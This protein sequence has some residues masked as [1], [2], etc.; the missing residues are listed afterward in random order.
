[1]I[2]VIVYEDNERLRHTLQLLM[3]SDSSLLLIGNY[4]DCDN[5]EKHL[6]GG[7]LPDV[8]LMDIDMPGIGGIEGVSK[9]KQLLP[10]VQIIMFTVFEDEDRLFKCLMAG[11]NG[12]ILKKNKPAEIIAAIKDVFAGGI[13][14]SPE[15]ARKVIGVFALDK[16]NTNHNLTTREVELLSLLSVGHTYKTIAV[17]L[18]ISVE[19]V[20]THLKNIYTKMHV[21]SGTEAV[22]KGLRLKI[23]K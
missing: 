20:R 18:N 19:T 5:I 6:G 15:I 10:D 11:A 4:A 16:N 12:Y 8:I 17:H 13:P 9:A 3:E 2:N 1:M 14:M 23:I 7:V 22:A 21:A